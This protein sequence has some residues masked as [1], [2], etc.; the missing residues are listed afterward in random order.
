MEI[1]A[2]LFGGEARVKMLRLFLMNRAVEFTLDEI[3]ARSRVRAPIAKKELRSL[4]NAGVI[5]MKIVSR[6]VERGRGAQYKVVKKKFPAWVFV[7]SFMYSDALHSLL[8][9][10]DTFKKEELLSRFKKAG[11]IKLCVIAGI[12]LR[13]PDSRIDLLIVGDNLKSR[14][15]EDA[16][17]LLQAELGK[18]ISYAVFDSEEFRYRRDMYDKLLCDIFE[19]PHER[20][21]EHPTLSTDLLRMRL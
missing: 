8:V 12:F 15:I 6:E 9:E 1:L 13:L 7:S 3:V 5:K 16:I 10:A 11:K 14:K 18:E 4:E 20:L 17:K 21:V 19:F 2:K